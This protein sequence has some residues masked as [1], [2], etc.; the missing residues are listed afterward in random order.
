MLARLR[1]VEPILY[2][3]AIGTAE[4]AS[5]MG[6]HI[7]LVNRLIREGKL[8]ARKAMND[9]HDGGGSVYIVSRRAAEANR[10]KYAAMESSGSKTGIPRQPSGSSPKV[11]R[12]APVKKRK[13]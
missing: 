1:E 11:N 2:D 9:R 3:D 5:I 12:S 4:A 13:S 10:A 6:V 8:R 7:T